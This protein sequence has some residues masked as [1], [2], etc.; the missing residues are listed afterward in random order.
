MHD[1]ENVCLLPPPSPLGLKNRDLPFE[2][3]EVF[4]LAKCEVIQPT[5]TELNHT[6][7]DC[8]NYLDEFTDIYQVTPELAQQIVQ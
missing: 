2:P 8:I 6:I 1:N 5:N 3:C 4:S 7:L